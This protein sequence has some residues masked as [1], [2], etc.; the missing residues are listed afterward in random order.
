MARVLKEGFQQLRDANFARVDPRALRSLALKT[1]EHI[2]CEW[3]LFFTYLLLDALFRGD[4][5]TAQAYQDKLQ[6]IAVEQ[7]GVKLLPEVYLVPEPLIEAERQNPQSQPRQPNENLPLV[8]AQSLWIVGQLILE[9]LLEPSDLDPLGR[10]RTLRA[11][12]EPVVQLALVAEDEALREQ[13][14][15]YGIEA[16]TLEDIAPLQLHQSADLARALAVLGANDKLHLSGRPVRRLRALMTSHIYQIGGQT[17]VFLPSMWDADG[18]YLTLDPEFLAA[19][20]RGEIAYV[21]R[22]WKQ[23][24]R[25]TITLLLTHDRLE[26]GAGAIDP[27]SPLIRLIVECQGGKCDS[28]RVHMDALSQLLVT[29]GVRRLDFL[30]DFNVEMTQQAITSLPKPSDILQ[31]DPAQ[32]RPL[33][34]RRELELESA[35]DVGWL[36]D[37]LRHSANLYEQVEVVEN[38][39]RLESLDFETGLGQGRSATVRDLLTELYRRAAR[40][41]H[42]A[43][44]AE[45]TPE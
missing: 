25:P 29:A 30:D 28:I 41:I 32:T 33:D 9:G 22:H 18:F 34:N 12:R 2:E 5:D 24:G 7:D 26:N 17:V 3:P 23:L 21:A 27:Q 1:F 14:A 38:L 37:Q 19:Q 42:V 36:L 39:I 4:R 35:Q 10:R 11:L 44:A 6:E 31:F 8:W 40:G 43:V 13:L 15:T 16:Q 20:L 45:A